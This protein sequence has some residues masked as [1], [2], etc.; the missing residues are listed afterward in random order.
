MFIGAIHFGWWITVV[1][2]S[3]D[4]V[5]CANDWA[6]FPA[7]GKREP[8]WEGGRISDQNGFIGTDDDLV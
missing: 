1:R 5:R 7:C 2:C 4:S 6:L 8:A 3:H